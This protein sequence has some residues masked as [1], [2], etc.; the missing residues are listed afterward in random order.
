MRR[1]LDAG[2]AVKWEIDE[3]LSDKAR[4]LRAEFRQAIH[5]LIGPDNFL[6][7]VANALTKA[8][9]LKLIPVGSALPLW[10]DVMTTSPQLFPLR[11]LVPRAIV[12]AS[13]ARV[14]VYDCLYVALA[15]REGCEFVT[16]DDKLVKNLQAQFPFIIPLASLP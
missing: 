7:E 1:V 13:Q 4:Q 3:D 14:A 9:K 15:E 11:P 5:D 12:I 6:A 10:A 2:V 8:E 16:A